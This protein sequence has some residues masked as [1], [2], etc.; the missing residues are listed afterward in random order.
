VEPTTSPGDLP[1]AGATRG[2]WLSARLAVA[3]LILWA[4]SE[5][6][7]T[8]VAVGHYEHRIDVAVHGNTDPVLPA[9]MA[10]EFLDQLMPRGTA[11]AVTD[12]SW[13][14]G[15]AVAAGAFIWLYRVRQSSGRLGGSPAWV[16]VLVTVL[17]AG[18]VQLYGV[19]TSDGG[20]FAK[21]ALDMRAVAYPLWTAEAAMVVVTAVLAVRGVR[22]ITE[23]H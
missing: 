3:A 7:R 18:L 19:V 16:S 5:V 15:S 6:L 9:L 21:T 22:T 14:L 8:I 1:S 13:M 20:L 4:V 12:W 23:A 17:L 11:T 10:Y 2:P